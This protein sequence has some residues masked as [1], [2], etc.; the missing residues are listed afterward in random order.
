MAVPVITVGIG[1]SGIGTAICR[2]VISETE[3]S[4]PSPNDINLP[5]ISNPNSPQCHDVIDLSIGD[6]VVF[7]T[8]D[9]GLLTILPP[10]GGTGVITL[11]GVSGDTGISVLATGAPILLPL[12]N[13]PPA[14]III[15]SAST[16][17]G[18]RILTH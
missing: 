12:P 2:T 10:V 4:L 5:Y 1:A 9:A 11:K 15:N 7:L 8:S 18:V 13:P 6:N 14:S 3:N 16:R 17:V